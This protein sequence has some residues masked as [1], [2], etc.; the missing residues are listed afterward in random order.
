MS[1]EITD[2]TIWDF[3]TEH[4]GKRMSDLPAQYLLWYWGIRG[5]LTTDDYHKYIHS[6]YD[7]LCREAR[8]YIPERDI[9]G[10][11]IE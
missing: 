6:A 10:E 2:D 3:G 9:N 4:N 7:D 1:R 5:F 8:N 11:T